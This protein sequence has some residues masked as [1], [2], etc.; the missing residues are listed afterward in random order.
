MAVS[1]LM[2]ASTGLISEVAGFIMT[3]VT[4][5]LPDPDSVAEVEFLWSFL[6]VEPK[7]LELFVRVNQN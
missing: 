6:D 7:H 3:Y 5:D 2:R 4:F 1:A